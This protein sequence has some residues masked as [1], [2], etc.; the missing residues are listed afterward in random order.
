MGTRHTH[1][2]LRVTFEP[3][4][5]GGC[6]VGNVGN[7][8]LPEVPNC[9]VPA[10]GSVAKCQGVAGSLRAS[11][12]SFL[13]GCVG[14]VIALLS[15]HSSKSQFFKEPKS[16]V[17][18]RRVNPEQP[19]GIHVPV[20]K[21]KLGVSSCSE[22]VHGWFGV[23]TMENFPGLHWTVTNPLEKGD[24]NGGSRGEALFEPFW[25][26]CGDVGLAGDTSQCVPVSKGTEEL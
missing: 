18:P 12:R 6:D 24:K 7:S 1:E 15:S 5:G 26:R 4:A 8:V 3:R 14:L 20:A 11:S 2:L 21:S 13:K 16:G 9:P 17:S 10:L 23:A 19:P 22:S 25:L